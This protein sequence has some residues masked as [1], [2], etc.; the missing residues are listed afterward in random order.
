MG[1][2][3]TIEVDLLQ[4]HLCVRLQVS[5]RPIW[6]TREDGT[7]EHASVPDWLIK[8]VH[9]A[10][11]DVK[12]PDYQTDVALSVGDAD[13]MT[14]HEIAH[15]L[16]PITDEEV[17]YRA[18]KISLPK[19]FKELF[20][21]QE[22]V[23]PSPE[24]EAENRPI[25]A[26]LELE[27]ERNMLTDLPSSV[28]HGIDAKRIKVYKI[29]A[30]VKGGR[31][32]LERTVSVSALLELTG[33]NTRLHLWRKDD[34]PDRFLQLTG[35]AETGAYRYVAIV[36]MPQEGKENGLV[37]LFP[38]K[39]VAQILATK[40]EWIARIFPTWLAMYP[41]PKFR[42]RLRGR[43]HNYDDGPSEDDEG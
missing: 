26:R 42:P 23:D 5:N 4:K 33:E 22:G 8:L 29:Q 16:R 38:F 37:I 14:A 36:Y 21:A 25:F 19:N 41:S 7:T 1:K 10:K 40:H 32:R 18:G 30:R 6:R 11:C 28:R 24:D 34:E 20:R 2:P 43:R 15:L 31:R 27:N 3:S 9:G 39:M 13:E 35:K 17:A 12:L